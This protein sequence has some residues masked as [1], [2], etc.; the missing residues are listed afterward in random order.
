[1]YTENKDLFGNPTEEK[2]LPPYRFMY[3]WEGVLNP[4][5]DEQARTW[6]AE[7]RSGTYSQGSGYLK[8]MNDFSED[9]TVSFCC[10]GVLRELVPELETDEEETMLHR[11]VEDEEGNDLT[12]V[13]GLPR[14]LQDYLANINDEGKS[15]A[16]IA[17]QIEKGFGLID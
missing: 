12:F 2:L 1:M 15:F 6:V 11:E 17:A 10:L 14:P 7:L 16:D 9:D 4:I 8:H 13:Y 3:S 5:T